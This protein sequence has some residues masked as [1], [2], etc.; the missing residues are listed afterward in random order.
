MR[1]LPDHGWLTRDRT[2]AERSGNYEHSTNRRAVIDP[3]RCAD[4]KAKEAVR[5]GGC[6]LGP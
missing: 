5:L 3:C 4:T 6:R 1:R 2:V